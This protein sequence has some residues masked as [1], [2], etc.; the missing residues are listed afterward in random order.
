MYFYK[1]HVNFANSVGFDLST[2]R[3]IEHF[4]VP[5][6]QV[7]EGAWFGPSKSSHPIHGYVH[8]ACIVTKWGFIST[9]VSKCSV[10]D[11]YQRKVGYAESVKRALKDSFLNSIDK[12]PEGRYEY[13]DYGRQ[14]VALRD[15]CRVT[16][17]IPAKEKEGEGDEQGE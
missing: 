9:G 12:I 8:I 10:K 2:I 13:D 11:Q 16:F 15:Y 3:D 5:A 17:G 1:E 4:R 6:D 14:G 7:P